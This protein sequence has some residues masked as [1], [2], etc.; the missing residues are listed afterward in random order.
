[1]VRSQCSQ[2]NFQ[3]LFGAGPLFSNLFYI[4]EQRVLWLPR[5][6]CANFR[7]LFKNEGKFTASRALPEY[8]YPYIT[9]IAST[10]ITGRLLLLNLICRSHHNN[11]TSAFM[12]SASYEKVQWAVTCETLILCMLKI[13]CIHLLQ[14][15][16][17]TLHWTRRCTLSKPQA[18]SQQV[19]EFTSKHV[20]INR[21]S[22]VRVRKQTVKT[23]KKPLRLTDLN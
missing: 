2:S 23:H 22:S 7:S 15:N 9:P 8:N 12:C 6:K 5:G 11:I 10:A 1:M 17:E 20:K 21:K 19:D 3:P 4:K 18:G 13:T 14:P 16:P